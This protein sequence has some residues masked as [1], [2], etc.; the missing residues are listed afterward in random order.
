MFSRT[1]EYALKA[2]LLVSV[3]ASEEKKLRLKEIA[4]E[5]GIPAFF[6]GKIMQSLVKQQILQSTKGPN[7]GFFMND[8]AKKNSIIKVI[9][10]VDGDEFFHR[11]GMGLK[12][13]SHQRPCPIHHTFRPYREN[14]E[15]LLSKCSID[16]FSQ[17]IQEGKAFIS[18]L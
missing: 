2:I 18:N 6:L 10:A 7:G 5:L 13:C 14:L 3:K 4:D 12:N 9:R 17:A 8:E 16:D 15:R 1:C 11:C